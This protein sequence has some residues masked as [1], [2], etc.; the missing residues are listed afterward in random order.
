MQIIN[1]TA[2]ISIENLKHYFA[3]SETR[4][5][6]I[7]KDSE[8]KADKLLVYFSNLEV[9]ADII[10]SSQKDL[11][12]CL[13]EYLKTTVLVKVKSLELAAIDALFVHKG[14]MPE[15]N[16]EYVD[17]EFYD[18]L[19]LWVERLDS[20]PLYNMSII[21]HNPFEDFIN[22]HEIVDDN[23]ISGLNFVNLLK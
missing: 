6:I 17:N 15:K 20:L 21:Q 7:Y 2:P 14:F 19:D 12:E 10:F 23:N 16:L 18:L 11:F 9:K 3:D 8:L 4:Y 1:T 5:N 13:K 22:E